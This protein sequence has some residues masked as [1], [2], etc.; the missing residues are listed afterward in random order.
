MHDCNRIMASGPPRAE[1]VGWFAGQQVWPSFI[2]LE[3]P[4]QLK[5]A[6]TFEAMELQ[7]V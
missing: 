5:R 6:D 4:T 1:I 7:G 3:E 2:A